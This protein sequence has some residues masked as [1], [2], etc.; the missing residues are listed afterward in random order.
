MTVTAVVCCVIGGTVVGADTVPE[1]LVAYM[2]TVIPAPL[3]PTD[4]LIDP[5][6]P[7]HAGT[8]LKAVSLLRLHKL[9]TVHETDLI[10]YLGKVSSVTWTDVEGKL[11]LLLNLP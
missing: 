7:E 2:T 4:I 10:R 3:L 9:A 8:K 6:K 5:S 1:V 11:R